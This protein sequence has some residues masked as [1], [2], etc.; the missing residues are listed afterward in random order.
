MFFVCVLGFAV[1][2]SPPRLSAN[3]VI[4]LTPANKSKIAGGWLVKTLSEKQYRLKNS[5]RFTAAALDASQTEIVA[6]YFA[7]QPSKQTL[8]S[9]TF[10]GT[11]CFTE[12]WIPSLPNHP[13]G[14]LLA[15]MPVDKLNET[16]AIADVKRIASVSRENF[17]ENNVASTN[18]FTASSGVWAGQ[19][20]GL[21]YTGAGVTVAV[22]DSGLDTSYAGTEFPASYQA[23]DYSDF[24]VLDDDVRS[25]AG[26]GHGTH[27]TGSVLGRGVLSANN[28][29]N[30]GGS[31]KGMAPGANLVF[32]KIGNDTSSGANEAATI[33]A[34]KAAVSVYKANIITRSYGGWDDFM[35]GSD[36]SSQTADW[37]YSQG[38]AVFNS[39]GNGAINNK[40]TSFSIPANG[41]SGFIQID[42]VLGLSKFNLVWRSEAQDSSVKLAFFDADKNPIQAVSYGQYV[43]ARDTNQELYAL[44]G[45]STCYAKASNLSSSAVTCHIYSFN[46][47]TFTNADPHYIVG[48]MAVADHVF[49]VGSYCSR[50]SFVNS[51]GEQMSYPNREINAI[52]YFSSQ[53]PRVDGALKPNIASPGQFIISVRDT[54]STI[55][56]TEDIVDNDGQPGG[57]ANY[58]IMQGTSMA[59]PI[60]AGCAALLL[61]RNPY[62]TPQQL[63]DALA[64]TARTDAYVGTVP[65]T[66]WGAGKLNILAAVQ[67]VTHAKGAGEIITTKSRISFNNNPEKP[68]NGSI[69]TT[70]LLPK[71]FKL[72]R[73]AADLFVRIDD[74][75][76]PFSKFRVKGGTTEVY[77]DTPKTS[78]TFNVAENG[79]QMTLLCQN[80]PGLSGTV[81]NADG[82]D[83]Y[84]GCKNLCWLDN[85]RHD[86]SATGNYIRKAKTDLVTYFT[87]RYDL[88]NGVAKS[89]NQFTVKGF[90]DLCKVTE[91]QLSTY[92]LVYI[93]S[94]PGYDVSF[95]EIFNVLLRER[96]SDAYL[97]TDIFAALL[98]PVESAEW[99]GR[100]VRTL[101]E[102]KG[103]SGRSRYFGIFS[104]KVNLNNGAFDF[105]HP[106]L[107]TGAWMANRGQLMFT[108]LLLKKVGMGYDYKVLV[109]GLIGT[110]A[111]PILAS[112]ELQYYKTK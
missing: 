89:S 22:L 35:D 81:S 93:L 54:Y 69:S 90:L 44:T 72:P 63:Y 70:V 6:L 62:L 65:N 112:D 41:S 79:L 61:S 31:Y 38:T 28:I 15:K 94:D 18:A 45:T 60:T 108:A 19:A 7:E 107:M 85:N 53:G 110:D 75:E 99:K 66:T 21:P 34:L 5:P 33:S 98:P 50:N 83:V 16:L 39:A 52:S 97:L 13:H 11:E 49:T 4:Q 17:P 47:A 102:W 9:L 14:F 86:E 51:V 91:E 105:S 96:E 25:L 77:N 76:V 8:D 43:S 109:E 1:D 67:S 29:G 71:G 48:S 74:Y 10:I 103:K 64:G 92:D 55:P 59:T 3:D 106:S 42:N 101:T 111:S 95:T 20:W 26:Y 78:A 73:N 2:M 30:G 37:C 80:I 24:P 27:V 57:E 40:H 68:N 87:Y 88:K 82:V 32:L 56:F 104:A 58:L 100:S 23:K 46:N 36:A 84:V 12:T